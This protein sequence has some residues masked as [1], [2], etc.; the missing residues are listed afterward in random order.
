MRVAAD[1]VRNGIHRNTREDRA[2]LARSPSR[3]SRIP[4]HDLGAEIDRS[5]KAEWRSLS[6]PTAVDRG[7]ARA[8][9]KSLSPDAVRTR[10]VRSEQVPRSSWLSEPSKAGGGARPYTPIVLRWTAGQPVSS[11]ADSRGRDVPNPGSEADPAS[12]RAGAH[13]PFAR[14]R[15]EVVRPQAS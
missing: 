7:T 5:D 10:R 15:R 9:R 8:Q 6:S 12:P 3:M 2:E 14:M 13:S 4:P 11:P 1:A